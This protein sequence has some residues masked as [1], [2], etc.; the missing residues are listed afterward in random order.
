MEVD[1]TPVEQ[2]GKPLEVDPGRHVFVVRAPGHETTTVTHDV[3]SGSSQLALTAPTLPPPAPT[4]AP[5]PLAEEEEPLHQKWW[6]WTTVAGITVAAAVVGVFQDTIDKLV[7][8]AVFLP[9][10][11]GQSGNT[12]CQALAVTLRGLTLGELRAGKERPL[13]MKEALLGLLNGAL[14]GVTAGLGMFVV[15]FLQSN[16]KAG[17]LA[18]VVLLSWGLHG[19]LLAQLVSGLAVCAF[20]GYAL[21]PHLHVVPRLVPRIARDLLK[22]GVVAGTTLLVLNLH[23]KLDIL[24]LEQLV[25]QAEVGN[26][27]LGANL[28]EMLLKLPAALGVVIWSLSAGGEAG[29]DTPSTVNCVG[30]QIALSSS[31]LV[32]TLVSDTFFPS[33]VWAVVLIVHLAPSWVQIASPNPPPE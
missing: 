10:L 18:F 16:E 7:V 29:I 33:A 28:A 31:T 1:G 14:V 3:P 9:V 23:L 8:L 12:G 24:L 19:V 11:A 20:S 25:P 22:L 13:V 5:A 32:S 17:T 2:P 4:A 26:Y 6:L 27:S 15:A 21:W 30:S